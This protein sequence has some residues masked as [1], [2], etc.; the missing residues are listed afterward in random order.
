MHKRSTKRFESRTSYMQRKLQGRLA[1]LPSCH[2]VYS[3]NT[4]HQGFHFCEGGYDRIAQ[5]V[6]TGVDVDRIY[7]EFFSISSRRITAETKA[8]DV[9]S[10]SL[11]TSEVVHLNLW[12]TSLWIKPWCLVLSRPRIRRFVCYTFSHCVI[13]KLVWPQLE[14]V[15]D[16]KRRINEAAAAMSKGNP[17]RSKEAALNQ[18]VF[19]SR[20]V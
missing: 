20:D 14:N 19:F 1:T 16:L 2:L 15:D 9:G 13:V 10:L 3:T 5:K 12:S 8:S 6:F 11:T 18:W 7:V 17:V 4:K